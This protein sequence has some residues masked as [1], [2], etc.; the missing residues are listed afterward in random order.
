M[1]YKI[2]LKAS[3]VI[4][5]IWLYSFEN[6]SLEHADRYVNFIFYE[7]EYLSDNPLSGKDFSHIRNNHRCSK[8][9]SHVIF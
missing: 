4:K 6:W 1:G 3:E 5:N 7:I 2:S 8:I 9:K